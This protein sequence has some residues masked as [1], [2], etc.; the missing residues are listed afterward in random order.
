MGGQINFTLAGGDVM[1]HLQVGDLRM[2]VATGGERGYPLLLVHGFPLD[3]TMWRPQID[4][5]VDHCRVIAPD[6]RGF[7]G[8][9]V[10]P[11]AS[12]EQMA[13]D[14]NGLL[15][16]LEVREKVIFCGLSMGGYIGWQFWRK[17]SHRVAAMILCD[18]RSIP[19]TLEV[20][21][22]RR[23]LAAT[24]LAS[25]PATAAK[26]M[27]PKM[28]APATWETQP[29]LVER[30]RK[31]M[32]RNQPAGIAAALEGL[33]TRIDAREILPTIEAPTLVIVG[34]H[35]SI[36]NVEE[37]RQIADAIPNAGWVVVPEAGHLSNLEN[38]TVFNTAVMDFITL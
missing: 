34:E 25:G 31:M 32:E 11:A 9:D 33:A 28:F 8:T 12:M 3:H 38:P 23:K 16:V 1:K 26:V 18:T 22:G 24:T 35:D 20:A 13:D 14:L 15:E 4:F 2:A 10:T 29:E 5:F 21:E 19:D 27:L 30:V 36:S 17:Y 7:G 6:L 37:M